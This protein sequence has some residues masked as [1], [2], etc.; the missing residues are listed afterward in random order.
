M[1]GCANY[2]FQ[3][4]EDS[5]YGELLPY[6]KKQGKFRSSDYHTLAKLVSLRTYW[7]LPVNRIG[8][9]VW[10]LLA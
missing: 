10:L 1:Y 5:N 6:S 7:N 9:G 8:S 4:F 3:S 2:L